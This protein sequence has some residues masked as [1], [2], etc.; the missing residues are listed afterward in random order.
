MEQKP[1]DFRERLLN[2]DASG[3]DHPED[4]SAPASAVDVGS[5]KSLRPQV[6]QEYVGQ[7]KAK[8][9]LSLFIE[10]ARSRGEALDHVLLAGPPGLGKTTLA[11]IIAAEM[12][13]R[14]HS[15]TGPNIE[16]KGDLA[17]V[18]NNL[19]PGDVLFIDEVHRL[20]K[21][22]EE[23]LYSAMEDYKLDLIIG[24]GP[25]ARTLTIDLPRFTLVGATTR[26]GLLTGPLRDRFGVPLR[27]ELY[28]ADELQE[29]VSRSATLLGLE[30]DLQWAN[31]SCWR[32][33][34]NASSVE[35][36]CSRWGKSGNHWH[37]KGRTNL[38][39]ATE[40]CWRQSMIA[41]SVEKVCSRLGGS[42]DHW[43]YMGRRPSLV[44]NCCVFGSSLGHSYCYFL[45]WR[46]IPC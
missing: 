46:S 44:A 20:Q 17:A 39:W 22:I 11:H 29:I 27:L 8:A 15:I 43:H 10:A 12:G 37:C 7:K 38:Q 33:S 35:S 16:K 14:I 13:T 32:Q 23:I 24:T 5:E 28:P 31:E 40:S 19:Q 2:T 4:D 34:G 1:R 26:T 6:L 9:N 21:Q 41:S 25:T 42:N 30:I 3:W 45:L 18:L 36:V